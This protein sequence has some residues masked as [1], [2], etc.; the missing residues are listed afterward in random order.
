[1]EAR[2][3]LY[4]ASLEHSE[5][6]LEEVRRHLTTAHHIYSDMLASWFV[7]HTAALANQLGVRLQLSS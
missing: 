6:N 3:H 2:S 5:G 7:T 1:M 4:F